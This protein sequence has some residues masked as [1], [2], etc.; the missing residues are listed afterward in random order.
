MKVYLF[1]HVLG[2]IL[3]IGNIIATAFWKT[4][5]DSTGDPRTIHRTSRLIL[6]A[7]YSFTLTGISML[8][9]FGHLLMHEAGYDLFEWSWLS[10]SYLLFVVSGI[11]WVAIL[12][13]IQRKM[14]QSS[15]IGLES[16]RIPESYYRYSK[17][18]SVF[19]IVSILLPLVTLFLMVVKP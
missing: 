1:L 9:I 4:T 10:A 18:W 15:K 12:L 14:V 19:G 2:A 16:G 11:I 6:L 13:P 7:D 17:L 5:S 8:L 3:F